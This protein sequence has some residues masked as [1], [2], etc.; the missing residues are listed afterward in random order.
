MQRLGAF[1]LRHAVE[2]LGFFEFRAL[3]V[4]QFAPTG[5]NERA[6][7]GCLSG[8]CFVFFFHCFCR[9]KVDEVVV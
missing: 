5:T 6:E 1:M 8:Y 4:L 9:C 7:T 2:R 3:I